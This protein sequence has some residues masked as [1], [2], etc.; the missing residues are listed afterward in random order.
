MLILLQTGEKKKKNPQTH[1]I[2]R[3]FGKNIPISS[4]FLTSKAMFRKAV[5]TAHTTRSLSIRSSST[6]IG[7][8]F[9]LRTAARMY[10]DHCK[11][12]GEREWEQHEES[13]TDSEASELSTE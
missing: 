6:N 9:S 2:H 1:S 10:T 3:L 11:D 13:T 5:A 8:P 12:T 4:L 7:N